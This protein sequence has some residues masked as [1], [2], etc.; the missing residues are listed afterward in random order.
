MQIMFRTYR[1]YLQH[2]TTAI[3]LYVDFKEIIANTGPASLHYN[4]IVRSAYLVG[5]HKDIF[6][7]SYQV[8][9]VIVY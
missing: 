2:I 8:S 7:T 6:P 5:R 4:E 3:G 1:Q 9:H